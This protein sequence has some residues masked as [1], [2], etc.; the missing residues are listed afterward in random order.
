MLHI[1]VY[2]T[3]NSNKYYEKLLFYVISNY[4]TTYSLGLIKKTHTVLA[5]DLLMG[6]KKLSNVL[7]VGS[8]LF[9]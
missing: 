7:T 3:S 4:E 1:N 8:D 6:Q 5:T 9:S 2:L